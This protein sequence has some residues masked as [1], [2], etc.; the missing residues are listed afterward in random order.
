MTRLCQRLTAEAHWPLPSPLVATSSSN[1][2]WTVVAYGIVC[3]PAAESTTLLGLSDLCHELGH[4]LVL[5]HEA[6]LYGDFLQR[7]QDYIV[8][9]KARIITQQR[10]PEYG[11]AYDLLSIMWSSK[12]VVEFVCD[13]VA[14]YLAGPSFGYQHV[15]LCAGS[16][17]DAYHPSLGEIAE[18]PADDARLRGVVAALQEMGLSDAAD[19]VRDLWTRYISWSGEV[20]PQDYDLAYPQDLINVLAVNTIAGCRAL[21]IQPYQQTSATPQSV[22]G[23]MADSWQMFIAD[24]ESFAQWEAAQL[25]TLWVTLGF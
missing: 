23:F 16:L 17:N 24:P 10:P 7:L 21:G 12:W 22:V 19:Q 18:H 25:P 15:R 13:M 3:V 20:K 2:Y 5:A 6:A 9:E 4:H 11:P 1:Y 8:S 14:T